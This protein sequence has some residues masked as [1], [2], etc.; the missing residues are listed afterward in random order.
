MNEKLIL[1]RE[2]FDQY[3]LISS[4]HSLMS[5]NDK[6]YRNLLPPLIQLSEENQKKLLIKLNELK[7]TPE[8]YIAA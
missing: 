2:T 3:N 4:L 7:F 6:R 5:I 8:N 1:V